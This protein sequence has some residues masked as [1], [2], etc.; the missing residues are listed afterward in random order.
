MRFP[1]QMRTLRHR[2]AVALSC[3]HTAGGAEQFLSGVSSL[4][5][6]GPQQLPQRECKSMCGFV[7]MSAQNLRAAVF[8]HRSLLCKPGRE[9]RSL[10]GHVPSQQQ[11]NDGFPWTNAVEISVYLI[12]LTFFTSC[13]ILFHQRNGGCQPSCIQEAPVGKGPAARSQVLL[14]VQPLAG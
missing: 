3:G 12:N 4:C 10:D 2:E 14:G 8:Y 13:T 7:Y 1:L 11:Q 9:I 6:P 5:C